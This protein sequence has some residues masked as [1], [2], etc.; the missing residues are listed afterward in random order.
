MTG[1]R[2]YYC[3]LPRAHDCFQ[4]SVWPACRRVKGYTIPFSEEFVAQNT[5]CEEICGDFYPLRGKNI[6]ASNIHERDS[7]PLMI[8]EI[9]VIE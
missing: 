2:H 7:M 4:R 6:L 1:F 3:W 8:D 9:D 5:L